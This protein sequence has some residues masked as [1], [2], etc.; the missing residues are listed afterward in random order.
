MSPAIPTDSACGRA[1]M[2]PFRSLIRSNCF[3]RREIDWILRQL[4]FKVSNWMSNW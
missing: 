4:A 3:E 2:S 1:Q